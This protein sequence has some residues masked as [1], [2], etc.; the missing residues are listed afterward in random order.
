MKIIENKEFHEERALFFEKDIIIKS[1]TFD[2]GESPLKECENIIAEACK[3]NWRYP[4]WYSKNITVENCSFA[5]DS[6]AGI[7]YTDNIVMKSCN[8]YAPKSIRRV[9][10]ISIEDTCFQSGDETLWQ[11]RDIKIK[12]C[13]MNGDYIFMN[14]ENIE[15]DGLEL[16]GK[17]SFDGAKNVVIR[18]SNIISKD[19]FWNSENITVYDSFISGEY[20]G[21]NAKN[22]T[23]IN[24]TVESLQGFC[25]IDGLVMK[26]CKTKET[27]L[28]FEYS[29]VDLD[30]DG[31]V[32]SILNPRRGRIMLHEVNQLSLEENRI[33]PKDI[34]I[35]IKE[36]QT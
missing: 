14:S 22:L 9:K 35:I 30:I 4:F 17:Y 16:N 6:R 2:I 5:Q 33:N 29:S 24:C 8:V 13:K 1:C 28:A 20:L 32:E 34:Q 31:G 26:N 3:F 25:Y 15:I 7:W 18:N 12:S 23:F 10:S 27:T 11:C 36:K 19:A 21:W